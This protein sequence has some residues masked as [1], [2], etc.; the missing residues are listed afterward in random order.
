L[1]KGGRAVLSSDQIDDFARDGYVI[2][3]AMYDRERIDEIGR[4]TDEL[5]VAPEAPGR[6]WVYREA[7]VRDPAGRVLQ[8]IENFCP[9][10]A[11]F[12]RLLND[13]AL[14]ACVEQL[15]GGPAVM[16]K[17]KINFKM[18][19]GQGFKPHQDQQAGWGIYAPYFITAMVSIDPTNEQN[20]CLEMARGRHREGLIGDE[21]RPLD[22]ALW[23]TL[24][25]VKLPTAPGDVV[26]F[27]SFAPHASAPNMT[28]HKRRVLYVTYNRAEEGDHRARYF[29]DKRKSFPPDIER[30]PG[31]TYVFRV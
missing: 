21:W 13:G 26:F 2:A 6:H 5:A 8:R 14:V 22:E 29:A 18:P 28:D 25:L 24:R 20:G 27:D 3:P 12:D 31:K 19:G 9:V 23:S 11:G 16:F 1:A 17:D 10:H 4:W 30:E 15:L 7:S